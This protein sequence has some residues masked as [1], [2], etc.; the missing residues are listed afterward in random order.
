[1]YLCGL[2]R[3]LHAALPVVAVTG[4]QLGVGFGKHLQ[5][6][7]AYLFLAFYNELHVYGQLAVHLQKRV[8]RT[9]FRGKAVFIIRHAAAVNGAVAYIGGIGWR[10]PLVQGV[11]RLHIIM[12]VKAEGL[13]ALALYLGIDDGVARRGHLLRLCPYAAQRLLYQLYHVLNALARVGDTGLAHQ[14]AQELCI[15]VR[16][17]VDIV[18]YFLHIKGHCSPVP[19]CA[20][21]AANSSSVAST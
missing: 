15:F 16:V 3:L 8:Y 17:L 20:V 13:I 4:Q 9:Y 10:H 12:V 2:A 21:Q 6:R 7:A 19:F 11:Y 14:R 5:V 1:M 18:I